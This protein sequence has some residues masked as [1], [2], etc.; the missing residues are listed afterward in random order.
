VVNCSNTLCAI[1]GFNFD[2]NSISSPPPLQL[3]RKRHPAGPAAG[4]AHGDEDALLLLVVE[5]GAVEHGAGLALEELVERQVAG[6]NAV[7]GGEGGGVLGRWGGGFSWWFG[8][9]GFRHCNSGAP[10][11]GGSPP[12]ALR[13]TP[14]PRKRERAN[15]FA[16]FF[17]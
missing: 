10:A 11:R 12:V 7:V 9:F 1:L 3:R 2:L 13:A 8:F 5:V 16:T 6:D 14:L 15:H 4:A 17:I